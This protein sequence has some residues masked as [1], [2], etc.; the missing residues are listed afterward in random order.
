[1]WRGG[2]NGGM[3]E[4]HGGCREGGVKTGTFAQHP[5]LASTWVWL[6]SVTQSH[7]KQIVFQLSY[8]AQLA[9]SCVSAAKYS[10]KLVE[11]D[12]CSLLF[13]QIC[14]NIQYA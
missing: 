9:L 5:Y 13:V 6:N 3:V 10:R 1:M 2:T 14:F 11:T 12:L 4:L 8:L 7:Y